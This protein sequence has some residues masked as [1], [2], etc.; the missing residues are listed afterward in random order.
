[1]FVD[2]IMIKC[3]CIYFCLIL[4][5]LEDTDLNADCNINKNSIL[6]LAD[7]SKDETTVDCSSSAASIKSS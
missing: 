1:M 3:I 2:K 6:K 4:I 7:S 5:I